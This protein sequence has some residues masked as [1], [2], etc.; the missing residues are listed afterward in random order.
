MGTLTLIA[1]VSQN[2]VIG[3]SDGALPWHIPADLKRFRMLTA[4]K[5]VIMG[6]ATFDSIGKPL[7]GRRNIVITRQT[8]WTHDGVEVASSIHAAL[9]LAGDVPTMVIGGGEIYA[10]TI[11]MADR[12]EITWVSQVVEDAAVKFPLIDLHTWR[13]TKFSQHD[14]HAFASYGRKHAA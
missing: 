3:T 5:P 1:A 14:G 12:L 8:G 9:A 2:R 11:A 6:R 7:P 10:Q 13:C 4:G